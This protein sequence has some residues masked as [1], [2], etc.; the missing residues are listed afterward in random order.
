MKNKVKT[1]LK[2]AVL[3][4]YALGTK[5]LPVDDRIV[6]FESSLGRNSTGS[7]RAVC[8]YMVKKGLDKH[9]KLYYIL[10]DKKN[11]NNGI[12]NLPKSVKRVRN[13]RILYYYLFARAGFI[14]SD[15]RFQNYMIKRKNCTYVQTWHGTPLK[16][17]ALD[18]TSVNM[19]VSK[20][21]E[22]YKREF[23]ENSATW[24][25]LVSQNSFSSK[26]LPG[27]F[28]YKGELLEIGYPRN[29]VLN[30]YAKNELTERGREKNRIL[31]FK[32]REKLGLPLDKKVMLYAPTWRDNAFVDAENYKFITQMDMDKMKA[33]FGSDAIMALKYHYLVSDKAA[34]NLEAMHKGFI[35]TFNGNVDISYLYIAADILIT[36]YSSVM[37]DYSLLKR[38][39][40]FYDFD[41]DSYRDEMRGFYFDFLKEAPGPVVKETG[42]LIEEIKKGDK[43][44]FEK[45]GKKY[46]AFCKKYHEYENGRA[47]EKIVEIICGK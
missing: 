13:S 3:G 27:A 25:Y 37:F 14:V 41:L 35:Y 17:L 15:T 22:E 44:Y 32:I 7:P 2:K 6:I 21:I 47:S 1:V 34:S 45:Y 24:D 39:M 26:V 43:L 31:K 30:K 11:V 33:A 5:L 23:V 12:R 38:P 46:D 28:G 18:M 10:D 4:A 8:D 42:E 16:K 9:Y 19:S 29:D 40:F 20:D 36:D